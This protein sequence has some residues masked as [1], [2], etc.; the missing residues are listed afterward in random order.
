LNFE[1][2]FVVGITN[3]IHFLLPICGKFTR[4]LLAHQIFSLHWSHFSKFYWQFTANNSPK[5]QFTAVNC[6]RWTCSPHNCPTK[7]FCGELALRLFVCLA[8]N[9]SVLNWFGVDCSCGEVQVNII[10][11]I[12]S[13]VSSGLG[14]HRNFSTKGQI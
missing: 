5:G 9:L 4:T 3:S 1:V 2:N 6:L 12:N 14:V 7:I 10:T 13:G 11:V 8:V